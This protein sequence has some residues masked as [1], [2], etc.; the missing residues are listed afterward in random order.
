MCEHAALH[1]GHFQY[2]GRHIPAKLEV[3][4]HLVVDRLQKQIQVE[5]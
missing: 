4:Y 3:A 5:H 1:A 2:M